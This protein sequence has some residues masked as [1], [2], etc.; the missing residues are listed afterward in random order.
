MDQ[1]SMAVL[2]AVSSRRLDETVA[3]CQPKLTG[4]RPLPQ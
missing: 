1:A 4:P 3:F 2:L